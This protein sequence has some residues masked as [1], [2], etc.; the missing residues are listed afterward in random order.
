MMHRAV[1]I[2]DF[3]GTM[4]RNEFYKLARESLLPQDMPDYWQEYREG[5]LT[6]LEALQAIFA[7]IR[8]DEPTVLE[9]VRRMD[10]DPNLAAAVEVLDRAGWSVVV[11]SAGCEWYIRRHLACLNGLV[12]VHAN[13]GR[14]EQ[15]RGL[16]MEPPTGSPFHSRELGVDKAAIV[17]LAIESGR[18]TAFAGDGIPDFEAA[19]L[20][21]PE[22]RFA[23]G[24]LADRLR[25]SGLD[26]RPFDRWS[27]IVQT[28]IGIPGSS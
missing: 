14:F 18:E 28:L 26:Y 17:R 9:V 23:R 27:R 11:A 16:V 8:A 15:G 22:R 5:R 7:S 3:D 24:D 13:P 20:V 1:L 6:H 19:R 21:P 4:T 2:S 10:L 25:A 12:E